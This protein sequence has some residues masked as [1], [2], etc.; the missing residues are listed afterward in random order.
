MGCRIEGGRWEPHSLCPFPS[1]YLPPVNFS[2]PRGPCCPAWLPC[3]KVTLA[4]QPTW[5][6]AT[7]ATLSAMSSL[8]HHHS[9]TLPAADRRTQSLAPDA[10]CRLT[11]PGLELAAF[12]QLSHG[13]LA[14]APPQLPTPTPAFQLSTAAFQSR[15]LRATACQP[16]KR[17][18]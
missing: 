1:F 17:G 7:W 6:K 5:D 14:S 10:S 13:I 11:L 4:S 8:C 18:N 3:C 2:P 16:R 15:V 9:C 12:S